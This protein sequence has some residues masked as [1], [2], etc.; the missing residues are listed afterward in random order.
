MTHQI[1]R[2]QHGFKDLEK[3]EELIL[4]TKAELLETLKKRLNWVYYVFKTLDPYM[5]QICYPEK[6]LMSDPHQTF[7]MV[8]EFFS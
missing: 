6:S 1:L 7:L 4:T 2:I 3:V 8:C 5:V